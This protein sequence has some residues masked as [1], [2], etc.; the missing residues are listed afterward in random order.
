M[1]DEMNEQVVN[2]MLALS[3][4]GVLLTL[5]KFFEQRPETAPSVAGFLI[6]DYTYCPAKGLTD[7]RPTGIVK[8]FNP[9]KGFGFID[10]PELHTTFG[11]DVFLHN[12]QLGSFN[13]GDRVTFAVGIS[14]D[15]KPQ[16]FDLASAAGGQSRLT[17]QL[18]Q[19]LM[20][21]AAAQQ[22]IPSSAIAVNF[23]GMGGMP[24]ARP[25]N[26]GTKP[27]RQ[28]PPESILGTFT[29]VIKSFNPTSGYGFIQCPALAALG[30]PN[31]A[32][33]HNQQMGSCQVGQEVQFT[34]YV[35]AK[36]QPQSKDVV[37]LG[38]AAKRQRLV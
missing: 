22:T 30:Y 25:L 12:K 21:Q 17:Q 14:K 15:K 29:G 9:A 7:S 36:G 28:V 26:L 2:T 4:Q 10:C 1:A 11:C 18:T 33:L 24:Q 5:G 19:Q 13:I 20:A 3:E 37:A 16:A 38:L 31:D 35:N 32:F 34:A 8:S 27:P 23:Q 6:P